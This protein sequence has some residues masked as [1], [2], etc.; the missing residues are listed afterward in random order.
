MAKRKRKIKKPSIPKVND[1]GTGGIKK[2]VG[3][4]SPQPLSAV[5]KKSG[6][7]KTEKSYNNLVREL[8]NARARI[9]AAVK[10]MGTDYFGPTADDYTLERVL[11][12]LDNGEHINRIYGEVRG[13]HAEGLRRL[14]EDNKPVA[15]TPTGWAITAREA[16]DAQKAINRA[17]KVLAEARKRYGPS[18]VPVDYTIQDIADHIVNEEGLKDYTQFLKRAYA[19]KSAGNLVLYA[20]SNEPVLQ[21]EYDYLR[22]II[23]RENKRRQ[24]NKQYQNDVFKSKGRLLT[25]SEFSMK[26]I[27]PE[28]MPTLS[29]YRDMANRWDDVRRVNK[30]NIWLQNFW[31]ALESSMENLKQYNVL[32]GGIDMQQAMNLYN[33]IIGYLSQLDSAEM[34]ER[35]EM[36]SP[37]FSINEVLYFDP[38]AALS[39]LAIILTDWERFFNEYG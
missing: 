31:T 39:R 14:S 7:P 21:G 18:V 32:Y 9:R 1:Y 36:Y 34:V 28:W 17:N 3:G 2:I 10:R 38:D 23:E 19:K 12:R 16:K 8:R 22:Q 30:A 29:S 6:R 11:Q 24:G 15:L 13:L 4:S 37:N 5:A 33:G 25:Q 26:D 35:A 20:Q 27:E